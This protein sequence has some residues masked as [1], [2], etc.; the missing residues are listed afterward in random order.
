MDTFDALY[1]V[2]GT[3]MGVSVSLRL[4]EGWVGNGATTTE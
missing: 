3:R 1:E 4:S 2:E